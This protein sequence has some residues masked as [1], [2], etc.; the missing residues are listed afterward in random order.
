MRPVAFAYPG[1]LDTRTG[2]YAYD[3]RLIAELKG[4]GHKVAL[5]K[6]ADTFPN[7]R[8]RDIEDAIAQL[9]AV[10]AGHAIVIDGLALGTLPAD[11]LATLKA[12]IVA[13]VHHPLA[14]ETGLAPDRAERLAASERAA[15]ATAR[16]VIVTS[17]HTRETLVADFAVPQ[18]K[19]TVAVPGLDAAWR[20]AVLRRPADPPLIVSVASISER[21]GFDTL[22]AALAAIADL[23]WRAVFVGSIERAPETVETLKAQIATAGLAERISIPGEADEDT[24][25]ALYR[26]ATLFALASRYEGFGMVFA[27]AMASGL[28]IVATRGG[29]VGDVVPAAAGILVEVDDV[30][31]MATALR[32]VLT[33]T[34]LAARLSEG[35]DEMGHTFAGWPNTGRLVSDAV[36][37][38]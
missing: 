22:T 19:I 21:K 5:V 6:L 17:P 31:G 1:D 20:Q 2:G 32:Q 7:P 27:E 14:L 8:E 26:E 10:P 29:A 3:R 24:I 38:L 37:A 13:L 33:D 36:A 35:A 28:P 23:S 11:R 34:A 9:A 12:P 15:L 30:E 4:H 25:R 16:H 18:G